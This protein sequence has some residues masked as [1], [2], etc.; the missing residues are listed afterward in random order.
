MPFP[1][2]ETNAFMTLLPNAGQML[3]GLAAA[4]QFRRAF[5]FDKPGF[6]R[7]MHWN[8]KSAE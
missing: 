6:F 7:R 2:R 4:A 5:G 3:T 1:L 8:G